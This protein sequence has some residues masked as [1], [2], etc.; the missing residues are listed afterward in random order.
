MYVFWGVLSAP[1]QQQS[2]Q[3]GILWR[4]NMLDLVVGEFY[5]WFPGMFPFGKWG[6]EAFAICCVSS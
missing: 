2:E 6:R 1:S 4:A 5:C 3:I